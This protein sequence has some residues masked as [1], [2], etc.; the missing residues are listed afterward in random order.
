MTT[1]KP[2]GYLLIDLKPFTP[3]HLRLRTDIIGTNQSNAPTNQPMKTDYDV[4]ATCSNHRSP[5]RNAINRVTPEDFGHLEQISGSEQTC[6]QDQ[7]MSSCDDCGIVFENVHDLQRHIKKWCPENEDRKRKRE[8]IEGDEV[9]FKK[10]KESDNIEEEDEEEEEDHEDQVFDAL[11]DKASTDNEEVWEEKYNKYLKEGMN[12]SKAESKANE[13]MKGIYMKDFMAKYAN[14]IEYSLL[15]RNGSIH[16][17]IMDDIEEFI[18]EGYDIHHATK[19]S[20]NKNR[21]LLE[22]MWDDD[23]EMEVDQKESDEEESDED[24][25]DNDL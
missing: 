10:V 3:D 25:D 12:D 2:Y 4:E 17:Q 18:D 7:A 5:A 14:L 19:L 20:L 13:K 1:S 23:D 22:E 6:F 9:V 11:M 24:S 21:H 15:L 16:K 8:D